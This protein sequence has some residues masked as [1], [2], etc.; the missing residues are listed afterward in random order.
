MKRVN[1]FKQAK[2]AVED[3]VESTLSSSV[4]DAGYKLL[5][6]LGSV[7]FLTQP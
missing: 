2:K 5:N 6:S 1:I 3:A 4:K 7:D